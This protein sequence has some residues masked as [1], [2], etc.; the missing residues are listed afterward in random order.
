MLLLPFLH[1]GGC[2]SNWHYWRG[3]LYFIESE[4]ATFDNAES[5][6]QELG[7]HLTSVYDEAEIEFLTCK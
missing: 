7:G 3:Y 2:P 1:T 6:C 4:R 5:Q